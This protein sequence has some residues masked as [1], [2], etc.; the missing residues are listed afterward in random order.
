MSFINAANPG[1][2]INLLCLIFRVLHEHPCKF[3]VEELQRHCAPEEIFKTDEAKKRFREN[4]KFWLT[5]PHNLCELD[6][7]GKLTL[8]LPVA[9]V[10]YSL[11]EVAHQLRHRLMA[12]KFTDLLD[13]DNDEFLSLRAIRSF[14][15]ILTQDRYVIFKESLTKEN[16][17]SNF[18]KNFF[19]YI[20]RE[21]EEKLFLEYSNFLG[22]SESV[23][24]NEHLDPTRLIKSFLEE[25]FKNSKE[26]NAADFIRRLADYVPIIDNGEHNLTVRKAIG[27]EADMTNILSI[28][29]SH[30][31]NRLS[32]ERL[33]HFPPYKSDDS[34]AVTLNLPNGVTRQISSVEYIG[35]MK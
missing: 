29:L 1:S 33:L 22:L 12:I 9:G 11:A 21:A 23:G 20:P 24:D 14:A 3:T 30:A 27:V 4:L 32:E 26:L 15:Y 8:D 16:V 7:D 5:P 18:A 35:V 17:R 2:Q 31:L 19:D 28:N 25:V 10:E 34:D 13:P 6:D